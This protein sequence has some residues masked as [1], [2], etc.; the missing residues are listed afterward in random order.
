MRAILVI[1][2]M[3]APIQADPQ[4]SWYQAMLSG[5]Q[6][7][8]SAA[9]KLCGDTTSS[10]G[11]VATASTAAYDSSGN[12]NNCTWS[13]TAAGGIAGTYY[14]T[15]IAGSPYTNV[16]FFN[17]TNDVCTVTDNPKVQFATGAFSYAAW[18]YETSMAAHTIVSKG[19]PPAAGFQSSTNSS[20][21]EVNTFFTSGSAVCTPTITNLVINTGYVLVVTR[22][23]SH[24]VTQYIN[25]V[26]DCS[27]TGITTN[28]NHAGTNLT[29]GS[30]PTAALFM[31]GYLSAVQFW[32]YAL[33][34]TQVATVSVNAIPQ[35]RFPFLF[36]REDVRMGF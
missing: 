36:Q 20:G 6:L 7:V 35:E 21:V 24:V 10:S 12:G 11:C 8:T 3:L 2:L 26:K 17:G 16:G 27:A 31:K 13:G 5:Q 25:G 32:P 9:Y 19:T 15:G 29:I 4:A 18:F 1:L 30:E 34:P 23:A 33:T 22:T 14:S 28:V